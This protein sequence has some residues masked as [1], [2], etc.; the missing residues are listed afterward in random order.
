MQRRIRIERTVRLLWCSRWITRYVHID[1]PC[2]IALARPTIS[3]ASGSRT[4][5]NARH[6]A[7]SRK[8]VLPRADHQ[9]REEQGERVRPEV[10][11]AGDCRREHGYVVQHGELAR[12]AE[13]RV[14]RATTS[15]APC[16]SRP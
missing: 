9:N 8:G 3:F 6:R 12:P 10:E 2:T 15:A 16:G 7:R 14:R 11:A 4:E 1:R 5:G 13:R